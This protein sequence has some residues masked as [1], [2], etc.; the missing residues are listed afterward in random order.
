MTKWKKICFI[1]LK[2][3]LA[4]I[5]IAVLFCV[6]VAHSQ[7]KS[8]NP[9]QD[10]SHWMSYIKDFTLLKQIAIPGAHDSGTTGMMWMGETQNLST[11]EQLA[12]G[13]RYL[14]LRVAKKKNADVGQIY[15][16]PLKHQLLSDVLTDVNDFLTLH[17]TETVLLDFQHFDSAEGNTCALNDLLK[18][19]DDT[20]FLRN[21]TGKTDVEF[22]DKLKLDSCRGKV[23]VFWGE[24]GNNAESQC[25]FAN[26]FIFQ[27]GN[28]NGT[29]PD[30]VLHSYYQT[31]L[32]TMRSQKFIH[33]ALPFYIENYKTEN[34]GL[35]VLQGQLTDKLFVFGPRFREAT[36]NRGMNYFMFDLADS[37]YLPYVNIVM[38]DF[39]N[40]E[41]C[42]NTLYLNLHKDV[43]RQDKIEQYTN[44]IRPHTTLWLVTGE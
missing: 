2:I 3:L 11:S 7:D 22:F 21:Q 4:V 23:I 42:C 15:H 12:C 5:V 17:P 29:K 6:F 19:I 32:N 40:A 44:M 28:D 26:D 35:F 18:Y 43:V 38:R 36:H 1:T 14:D 30:S 20:K 10:L 24:R 41:K 34:S 13:V 31:E 25:A 8:S 9:S 39:V 37:E 27:R 16:G 33:Q